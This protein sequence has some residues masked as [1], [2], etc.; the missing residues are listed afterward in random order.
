MATAVSAAKANGDN[1]CEAD[2][3][4]VDMGDGAVLPALRPGSTPKA[5]AA[6]AAA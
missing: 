5:L 2:G 3:G 6:D 4:M 1:V